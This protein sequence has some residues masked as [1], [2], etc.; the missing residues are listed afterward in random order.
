M[1]FDSHL[2][3][4]QSEGTDCTVC[5]VLLPG[6]FL[7]MAL[8]PALQYFG[9]TLNPVAAFFSPEHNRNFPAVSFRFPSQVFVKAGNISRASRQTE[10][11]FSGRSM[12]QDEVQDYLYCALRKP[13]RSTTQ[14][15]PRTIQ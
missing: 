1:L 15:P 5:R 7:A 2:L 3:M 13:R 4:M 12:G 9:H 14:Q 8:G 11:F 6:Q 10:A